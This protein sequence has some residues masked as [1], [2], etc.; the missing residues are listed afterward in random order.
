MIPC[1]ENGGNKS[2]FQVFLPSDQNLNEAKAFRAIQGHS[3]ATF[4]AKDL[5]WKKITAT[6]IPRLL[7][8]TTWNAFHKILNQ[9]LIPGGGQV[10]GGRKEVFFSP[11]DPRGNPKDKYPVYKFDCDVVFVVDTK[12]AEEKGC[13]F[14]LTEGGAV[15]C[16]STVPESSFATVFDTKIQPIVG[17]QRKST[18]EK[19]TGARRLAATRTA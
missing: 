18:R 11:A 5:G 15:L 17:T 10:R 3:N 13:C 14:Y 9:G 12:A 2:R 1:L 6:E 7:H 16:K 8:G 4:E 19:G